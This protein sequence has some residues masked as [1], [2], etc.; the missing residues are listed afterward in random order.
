M[1][2]MIFYVIC[3][4]KVL[5]LWYNDL[6]FLEMQNSGLQKLIIGDVCI[7]IIG[8][9]FEK[10][11]KVYDWVVIGLYIFVLCLFGIR[12]GVE[13]LVLQIQ[14]LECRN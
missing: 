11:F 6:V 5:I 7:E 3:I 14:F 8:V 10:G 1:C 13:I 2:F 12:K 9:V 4:W